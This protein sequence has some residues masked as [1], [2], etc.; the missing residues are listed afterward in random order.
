MINLAP[1]EN[2]IIQNIKNLK[3]KNENKNEYEIS[4]YLA[5]FEEIPVS[6]VVMLSNKV[7][8]F[9]TKVSTIPMFRRKYIASTLIQFGIKDQR[10]KGVENIM[11]VTDK[12]SINEKFYAFNNFVEFGQAFALDVKDL[13]KYEKFI[14]DK[15][16]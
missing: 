1:Q 13:A 9:V 2:A 14:N 4:A 12:Y 16:I 15:I 3:F 7:E 6:L 8:T 5:Y 11:L 10:K